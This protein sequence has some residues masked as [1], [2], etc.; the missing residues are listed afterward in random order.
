MGERIRS[1]IAVDISARGVVEAVERFQ[2]GLLGTG[3]DLKP[4]EPYNLHITLIFLG[5]QPKR[6]L[7]EISRRLEGL[8]HRRFVLELRGVGAFP[9]PSN[10]RVVWIDVSRGRGELTALARDVRALA[11]DFAREEEEFTPHL[12][13]ARVKGPRNKDKLVAFL[14]AHKGDYFGEV[15]VAEVKLKRSTLT[16][17]GPI[18]EDLYA[19][20]LA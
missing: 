7:D 14:E 3:A 12:T 1:F 16:P 2:R 20:K 4:V 8:A 11:K 9:T 19:K 13:V 6:A 18:Y 5:E 15:E 17:R 10:P